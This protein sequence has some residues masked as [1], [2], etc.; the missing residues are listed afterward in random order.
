MT[1]HVR[2]DEFLLLGE[3]GSE[4]KRVEVQG[5]L[6]ASLILNLC[7]LFHVRGAVRAAILLFHAEG[8]VLEFH[9]ETGS[10]GRVPPAGGASVAMGKCVDP[11]GFLPASPTLSQPASQPASQTAS[12]PTNQQASQPASLPACLPAS[13]LAEP[14]P[15]PTYFLSISYLF[16]IPFPIHFLLGFF[17]FLFIF[18]LLRKL[19][20]ASSKS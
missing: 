16:P 9:D 1:I 3:W 4:R 6:S 7:G 10:G 14:M 8:S 18:A 5:F 11:Q 19:R 13:Q 12:C 15:F 2:V 20:F 17:Y